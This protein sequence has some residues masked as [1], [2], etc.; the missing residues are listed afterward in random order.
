MELLKNGDIDGDALFAEQLKFAK[1]ADEHLKAFYEF[2]DSRV[3]IAESSH[4]ANEAGSTH[5]GGFAGQVS[6]SA[7]S[8]RERLE[9][10]PVSVKDI[11]TVRGF[12]A[13]AGSRILKGYRPSYDAT[14]VARTIAAGNRVVGKTSLDEFAMG[15]STETSA[16]GASFNPWDIGR[17]PGGSSGGGAVSV[18][19][20]QSFV[21]W[22]TDTGGSVRLPASLCGIVGY[23]PS[24][25]LLSRFGIVAYVSSLDSPSL[26]ARCALDCALTM[27]AVCYPDRYDSTLTVPDPVPDFVT[28]SDPDRVERPRIGVLR[29]FVE[30]GLLDSR[31]AERFHS[32]LDKLRAAG[33]QIEFVSFPLW[34]ITL[35]AYYIITTAE[36]SSNLARYDGVRFGAT[37]PAD[38]GLLAMYLSRRGGVDGFGAETKRRILLGTYVL[39]AGYFDAY[40]NKARALRRAVADEIAR[41]TR[42]FDALALPTTLDPAFKLGERMDDPVKMY[43]SDIATVI[44]N[45]AGTCAVSMP[46]GTVVERDTELSPAA[47]KLG[48]TEEAQA[49]CRSSRSD[50]DT[51]SSGEHAGTAG[52]IRLPVGFQ[53]IGSRL[54]DDRLL[55][56]ARWFERATGLGYEM[57]ECVGRMDA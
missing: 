34:D 44:A 2:A 46:C 38:D 39:S 21:G 24:Y 15:S 27:N 56:M 22:G 4:R 37:A 50:D 33:A 9:G 35:P 7:V 41:L 20:C 48:V 28:A 19:A 5:A 52:E 3:E 1:K 45:L 8:E 55:A 49:M 18:A 17:V 23:K 6:D 16:Y 43:M 32:A 47:R 30:G 53:L 25:G 36:C 42:E 54:K 14:V 26:F 12:A 29:E 40:Y 11:F 51:A 31:V 10:V 57:P 13:T